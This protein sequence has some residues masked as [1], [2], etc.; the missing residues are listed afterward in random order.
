MS[1]CVYSFHPAP[2]V[3]LTINLQW[4]QIGLHIP[5][6]RTDRGQK[7]E[8]GGRLLLVP[9]DLV[10]NRCFLHFGWKG[11]GNR[12]ERGKVRGGGGSGGGREG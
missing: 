9:A 10:G 5:Q 3:E 6:Q 7:D 8:Q 11:F 2:S 12:K 4:E 1:Q